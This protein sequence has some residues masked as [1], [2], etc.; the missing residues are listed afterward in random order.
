VLEERLRDW[1]GLSVTRERPGRYWL[2]AA[3][4]DRTGA[5]MLSERLDAALAGDS[6]PRRATL[7]VAI[8]VA[9]CP[10]DATDAPGLAA[11]ADLDLYAGRSQG[12]GVAGR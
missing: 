4:T 3:N 8:G 12:R 2:L 7:A 11:Q 10:D 6:G 1:R 9:V 5:E